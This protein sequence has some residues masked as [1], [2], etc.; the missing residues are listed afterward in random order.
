M[1]FI[2]R[3][4]ALVRIGLALPAIDFAVYAIFRGIFWAVFRDTLATA[5]WP[6]LLKAL[7][8]GLKFDLKLA[9]LVSLPLAVLGWIPVLDPERRP[10]RRAWL[11]YFA[12]AQC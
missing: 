6:D 4:P 11:A 8:I 5:S 7:S 9:L 12:A 3:L 10:A 2:R 1:A